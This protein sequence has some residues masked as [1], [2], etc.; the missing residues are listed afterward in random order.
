MGEEDSQD[1]NDVNDLSQEASIYEAER[2]FGALVGRVA[3]AVCGSVARCYRRLQ[4]N[5]FPGNRRDR[6]TLRELTLGGYLQAL[7]DEHGIRRRE[8]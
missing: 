5:Q 6:S 1:G 7:D 2:G 3:L 4:R 8:Y